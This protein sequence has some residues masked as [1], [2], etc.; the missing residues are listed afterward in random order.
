M[1]HC[2]ACQRR[3]GSAFGVQ[4][5][6]ARAQVGRLEGRSAQYVRIGDA[7]AR[8]TFSFCPDCAATMC[9]EMD[10]LPDAVAVPVGVFAQS[11]FP[12]PTAS[13]YEARQH[14]W[15]QLPSSVVDHMD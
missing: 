10:V 1:C 12:A 2:F 15:V 5:R 4:A 8:I 13:I 3:T 11:D 6:F 9:W 14:D 7:G